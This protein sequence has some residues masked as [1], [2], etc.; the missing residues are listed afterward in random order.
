V[1][2]PKISFGIRKI[3]KMIFGQILPKMVKN[4]PKVGKMDKIGQKWAKMGPN[5]H[6]GH[7]PNDGQWPFLG[8]WP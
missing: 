5:G 6:N 1:F 4:G 7:I 2:G 3:T 8:F